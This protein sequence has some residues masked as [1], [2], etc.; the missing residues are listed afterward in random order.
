MAFGVFYTAPLP[1][2]PTPLAPANGA[3]ATLPIILDWSDVP[4]PQP[5]GYELEISRNSSFT[6]I[7]EHAPQ[8]NNSTRTVLSLTSGTKFW[9]V[10]H[11]QGMASP[12][13][14]A[15]TN[16]SAVRSF[17][18]PSGATAIESVWLGGPPCSN[19]CPGADTLFSGQEIVGSLQ[20]TNAAPAGGAVVS[21][22]S[23][24]PSASGSHPS[25]VTIPAGFAFAQFRLFA[26]DVT[27]STPVTLTATVG[28][29]SASFNFTVYPPSLKQLSFCCDSTGGLLAGAHLSLNG[30]SPVGG[31]IVSL[32]SSSAL[33]DPPETVTVP[34]GSFSLPISIP[35]KAVTTTTIVTISATYKGHTV[36][37][38][39]KLYPQ[40][41]PVSLFLDRTS[42]IGQEGAA[43]TVRIQTAQLNEV[44]MTITSS[45][46]DIARPQ[47]FALIGYQSTV[48]GFNIATQPPAVSTEVTISATG[49]GVTLTATLTVHPFQTGPTL[50]SVSVN[51]TS[52][53]GGSSPT[54]TVTL[55]GAAPSGGLSVT[56]SDSHVAATVPASVSVLAGQL[57]A[58]FSITTTSVAGSTPVTITATY[59]GVTRTAILTVNPTAAAPLAAPSLLSPATDARFSR[60]QTVVFDWSDVGGATSY[61][62]QIDDSST[63]SSPFIVNQ[64]VTPST[65]STNTLPERKLFWRVR[66][67]DVNG[68]PGAWSASR[69]FEIK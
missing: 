3:T 21:L 55:S 65:Y 11:H 24:N 48:G 27:V 8:L 59:A 32:S 2:P 16:W 61:T 45:H 18:I 4:N 57:S 13:T 64:E 23:S 58:S 22:T 52:V 54:G 49:A 40:Q 35:T 51:P 14:T 43:G 7:E 67:N 56:L 50:T 19:P 12:S 6:D 25:S 66:A 47:P 34:G 5:S 38:Q 26:G 15:A 46:P 10:R 42:T 60:G 33:A 36:A 53:T 37:A 20:L 9:R 1:P 17:T 63:F 31:I 62:I 41:P 44:Q 39:L 29:S 30:R 68:N 28:S 69:R